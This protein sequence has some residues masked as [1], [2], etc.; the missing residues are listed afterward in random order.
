MHPG[1]PRRTT[2]PSLL[3]LVR[4]RLILAGCYC[5]S[6]IAGFSQTLFLD[7]NTVGQY[8]NNLIPWNDN[9]TGGYSGNTCYTES[10]GSGVGGSRGVSVFQNVDTTAT[11]TNGSWDF[12]TNGAA[13]LM[14]VL[15]KANGQV[16]GNKVQFGILNTNMSGLQN[17]TGVAFESFRFIP[18]GTAWSLRE[19]YRTTNTLFEPVLGNAN[20]IIGHWY[21][22]TIAMTNTSAAQGNYNAACA[23]YD[24]GADGNSPGTNIV[25]FSTLRIDTAQEIAT[26]KVVYPA[27]RAIQNGGIDAVDNFLVFTP[28]S[29]PVITIP[30]TNT[31]VALGTTANFFALADGPGAITYSWYTNGLL[32]NAGGA[33]SSYTTPAVNN[34]Y[35]NIM[36]IAANGN[37]SVTNSATITVFTP[38]V[39]TVTNL[40]AT[41]LQTTSATL[42]GQVLATGG[43][44]PTI[45]LYY[46]PSDAGT[47]PAGWSNSVSIG[48]QTGAFSQ[49]IAGLTQNTTYYFGARAINIAGTSWATPSRSFTTPGITTATLTNLPAT[50]I[51]ATAATMN[52]Q[53]LSTG[54]DVPNMTFYYGP[55]NGGTNAAA[56]SNNVAMGFQSGIFSQTLTVLPTNTTFFYAAKGVNA[57]GTSWAVPSQSF[58]TLSSNPPAANVTAVL[59]YHNNNARTGLNANE[60][61]LTPANVNTNSFGLVFSRP[62]DDQVYAQPLVMTNVNIPAKGMHNIVIVATVNDTVYAFDADDALVTTP[63]WQTNLLVPNSVAPKNSDMTGA[64]GGNYQDFHGNMGIVGT[65]VID[66]ATGTLYVLARTKENGVTF[67]QRLHA[68]DVATGNERPGSPIIVTATY[69]LAGGGTLTFDPMKQNPRP[70]LAL[71]NGIVYLG[72]SSHCDWGPYHGWLIGYSVTNLSRVSVYNTTANGGLGGIWQS[73]NPPA[74]DPSGNLYFE[75]GNGTFDPASGSFS[76][77]FL[78]LSTTNGLALADYFTPYN[79]AALNSTDAD[80]GSGGAMVLPDSM[81]SVAHPRLLVGGSKAGT[82]YLLD[83]DN[84]GHFN[85]AGDSQIVQSITN[86]TGQC[87]D[88]PALFNNTLY[89]AGTGDRLKAF[90]MS[91]GLISPTTPVAMS[92]SSFGFAAPS[93]SVS[94]NGTSN[95]IVWAIKVDGWGSGQ[96]GV[97]YAYNATN[98]ALELYNSSQAGARDAASGAVKFSVPVIANGK[99]YVGG[100]SALSVYGNAAGFVATPVISPNGG[101]FSTSITVSISDA[102]PGASIYYTLDNTTPTPSSPLYTGPFI[103]F[104]SVAVRAKAFKSGSIESAVA[105]A[106]FLNSSAIGTGTGLSGAYYANHFPTNAFAGAPTLTRIDPTVNYNWGSGSPDPSIGADNFTVRWTGTVQPQFNEPYTFYTSTDDGVRLY[107]NN[108]LVIDHW[109]DQ[110]TTE[111]SGTVSNALA[112]Q[113]KYNIQMD[114][115]EHG[116][117]ATATLSWSSPSTAKAI[118]PQTQLYPV[119][120]QL[121]VVSIAS[122][123]NGA[124][125]TASASVTIDANASEPGGTI[126]KVDFYANNTFLG[127]ISNG[128][129]AN[130]AIGLNAGSYALTA[131]ATDGTGIT[132]TSAPV[133]ITVTAGSGQPYGLPGRVPVAAYLNMPT[134]NGGSFPAKL[135]QTGAF[136]DTPNMVAAGGL[137]PYSVNVPLWSDNAAK[138]RWIAVPNNGVPYTP[139]EQIWFAPSGEWAFPAGTVFVKHFD[140][141]T[142]ETN[143]TVKRRLETR[144]LVRDSAGAVYGV[145]YKWRPD[146]TEADLLASSLSED[147]IVTNASGIRTQTWYYPSPADCLTCHTPAANYVLGVKTRQLNGNFTYPSTG[148]ADNQLRTMN[149][150]GLLYP[151]FNETNIATY[152]HLSPL[153]NVAASLEERARSY[154]DANC[155]QCHR[156]GG[157]GPTLDARYDTP[158]TNQNI[159]DALLQKGDLGYDNARVVVGKDVWRSVLWDRMN[160]MDGAIKMPQLARNLIDTNAVQVMGDWINSLPGTA[161]L[162]PPTITPAGGSFLFSVIVSLQHPDANAAL[163]YT[164]DDSLPTTSSPLYSSPLTLSSTATLK[165]KAFRAGFNDS[166]AATALFSIRPPVFFTPANRFT[167]SQFV[168]Q[169]SG[170]SGKSYVLQATADLTNWVTLSTNVA[171]ANIFDVADPAATNFLIRSYRAIELP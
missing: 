80:V 12:S 14:S 7:F 10:G 105:T 70:G 151:A 107:I 156:P 99:V 35:T 96:P 23:I 100:Q 153:T 114:Y 167:N 119:T 103:L 91:G 171:P 82:L 11:Y 170:I 95:G 158:L 118:I 160:T 30:L 106:T 162:A 36:V 110:G 1:Y 124:A 164:L 50:T 144:L 101:T 17:I 66:P 143:P 25:T 129:Y 163:R 157:T 127:S 54:N 33:S 26:N 136:S 166:V 15:V 13:I 77:S 48:T 138:T 3:S 42:N 128:P 71:V 134:T 63:Y 38:T 2:P 69:P 74:V 59:T 27:L 161:A 37:G 116:G 31:S 41:N 131:R 133:N 159:I 65:P 122:P 6:V 24:Y 123:A 83:R 51:Q 147:I 165:A 102:T 117:G 56:W 86:A 168:M 142:D 32:A 28:A 104:N 43:N 87:Y 57:A 97:L 89:L 146:N 169:L 90:T 94:A 150:M 108:Q 130:T 72:F 125:Y 132:V 79:Q 18:N 88:T 64:C 81:G 19:Q 5:L 49:A 149:R 34:S 45:T 148:T 22:F 154:L 67:V 9:G 76:D 155:A 44:A 137:V 111:W 16:S 98:I 53:V 78:R 68:L 58:T 145:T 84:M 109:V 52:G 92:P 112:A 62:V 121:A 141:A 40:P 55:I 85:A 113:Q 140:L 93:A 60:T 21:K 46:G 75:T 73:G 47:N 8:T 39:A 61:I 4:I 29:K 126:A 115:F 120:N 20:Y 152:S 135:S 139:D